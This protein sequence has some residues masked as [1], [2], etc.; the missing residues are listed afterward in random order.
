MIHEDE[1]E[2]VKNVSFFFLLSL[3]LK[4]GQGREG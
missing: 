1:K 4:S 2:K 3:P